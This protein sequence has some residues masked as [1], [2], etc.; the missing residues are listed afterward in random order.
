[1]SIEQFLD[2]SAAGSSSA[3]KPAGPS[4]A[5]KPP[6]G[7]PRHTVPLS[8]AALELHEA[9]HAGDSA[10]DAF[11]A[12]D[13]EEAVDWYTGGPLVPLEGTEKTNGVPEL[14]LRAETNGNPEN[15]TNTELAPL[16]LKP[17]AHRPDDA[18]PG[19]RPVDL[20]VLE[21]SESERDR[22]DSKFEVLVVEEWALGCTIRLDGKITDI[23]PGGWAE[24]Q[25][26]WAGKFRL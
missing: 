22:D 15:G 11:L 9:Q 7:G 2:Q 10:I 25:G 17:G 19:L 26:A 23:V 3:A 8:A 18:S 13:E 6:T 1:M 24:L 16:P 14:L 20:A 4:L 21:R 5:S 12:E